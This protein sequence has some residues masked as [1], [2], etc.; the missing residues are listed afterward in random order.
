MN[1]SLV[2]TPLIV[3]LVSLV[4]CR[5]QSE[6]R[7]LQNS[8]TRLEQRL[9][10]M[11]S[12]LKSMQQGQKEQ[13]AQQSSQLKN[14]ELEIKKLR[15]VLE[16]QEEALRRQRSALTQEHEALRNEVERARRQSD[17]K[18]AAAEKQLRRRE[19]ELSVE[20]VKMRERLD[21][22]R[23]RIEIAHREFEEQRN[24]SRKEAQEHRRRNEIEKKTLQKKLELQHR[25]LQAKLQAEE[26]A[27]RTQLNQQRADLQKKLRDEES[28]LQKKLQAEE[29]ALHKKLQAQQKAM[30]AERDAMNAHMLEVQ[31]AQTVKKDREALMRRE[32]EEAR[33]A[34]MAM[35]KE[36][37]QVQGRSNR[38]K[39]LEKRL[40]MLETK[41]QVFADK[42]ALA[43]KRIHD[44]ESELERTHVAMEK[45][46]ASKK[47]SNSSNEGLVRKL[48][49]ERKEIDRMRASIQRDLARARRTTS[50]GSSNAM[51]RLKAENAK[52]KDMLKEMEHRVKSMQ[53]S[54]G[55]AQAKSKKVNLFGNPVAKKKTISFG[56]QGAKKAKLPSGIGVARKLPKGHP[57][58]SGVGIAR[59]LPKGHPLPTALKLPAKNKKAT[60]GFG[61]PALPKGHPTFGTLNVPKGKSKTV[62]ISQGHG[63][64]HGSGH[65]TG[66]GNSGSHALNGVGTLIIN[67]EDGTV[68]VHIHGGTT[69]HGH[70]PKAAP[71]TKTTF[72]GFMF[73]DAKSKKPSKGSFKVLN[74]EKA[75]DKPKPK[76]TARSTLL[77]ARNALKAPA[78]KSSKKKSSKKKSKSKKKDAKSNKKINDEVRPLSA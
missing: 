1:R 30:Q 64:A 26:Q 14:K 51:N 15:A 35:R 6:R 63:S 75:S 12:Y 50:Q 40:A 2:F 77:R 47:R 55:K 9:K 36:V 33:A 56:K 24:A 54:H 57:L 17:E 27:L 74:F 39:E 58:P 41:V 20:R 66:H 49:Q 61:V 53:A 38:A 37:Q 11:D 69:S 4:G 22:E 65:G 44:L 48:T 18:L 60:V 25:D 72:G 13:K 71:K 78:K 7:N 76:S 59:Q 10:N 43:R 68:N 5:A 67:A 16:E 70:A 28:A 42:N 46:A 45:A 62:T 8:V 3:I 21:K 31:K 19:A 73:D 34:A 29:R 52:L 23:Q 32:I